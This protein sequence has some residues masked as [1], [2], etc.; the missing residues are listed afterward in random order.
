M[1]GQYTE[2]LVPF[3]DATGELNDVLDVVDLVQIYKNLKLRSNNGTM[4]LV[5]RTDANTPAFIYMTQAHMMQHAE[6]EFETTGRMY[7]RAYFLSFKGAHIF[8]PRYTMKT[9]QLAQQ[10]RYLVGN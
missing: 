10:V 2:P 6:S 7:P 5:E 3:W 8:E 4:V 1:L 9:T